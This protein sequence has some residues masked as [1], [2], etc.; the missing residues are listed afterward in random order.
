MNY[1]NL[2]DNKKQVV[3]NICSI[4]SEHNEVA[5]SRIYG[6][7]LTLDKCSDMD[8]AILVKSAEG[9]ISS[10][11]VNS[12]KELRDRLTKESG[13]NTDIDLVPHT[14]DELMDKCSPIWNP[15]QN[16]SLQFSLLLGGDFPVPVANQIETPYSVADLK[17]IQMHDARTIC[18]RQ[19]LRSLTGERGRIFVSKLKHGAGDA[20]ILKAC[21]EHTPLLYGPSETDKCF[22]EFDNLYGVDSTNVRNL[23]TNHLGG[24]THDDGLCLLKWYEAL[25]N[26]STKGSSHGIAYQ[27]VCDEMANAQISKRNIQ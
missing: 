15:R 23:I 12:L 21:K 4:V 20:I 18:R 25:F 9:I 7:W 22:T 26:L 19:I 10:E 6:S 1:N 13:A 16:P 24:I 5:S 11:H 14:E 17:I 2:P 27:K 8:I 3:D